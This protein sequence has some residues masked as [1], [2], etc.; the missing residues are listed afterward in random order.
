VTQNRKIVKLTKES[1]LNALIRNKR[2]QDFT[3]LYY[4]LWDSYSESLL[5]EVDTWAKKDGDETLYTITSWDLPHAFMAF[6]ATEVPFLVYTYKGR[7]RKEGYLPKIY[8]FF[9][10]QKKSGRKNRAF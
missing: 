9:N 5:K 6:R 10:R 7:V 3:V 1:Q 2:A 4:S 8:D